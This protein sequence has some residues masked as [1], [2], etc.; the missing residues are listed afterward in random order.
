MITG[1][2]IAWLGTNSQTLVGRWR[3]TPRLALGVASLATAAF[4][5]LDRVTE[6]LYFNF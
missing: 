2:A 4:V 1:F 3:W 6:F 5:N